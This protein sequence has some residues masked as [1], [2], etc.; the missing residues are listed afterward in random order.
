MRAMRLGWARLASVLVALALACAVVACGSSNDSSTSSSG[1]KA[2][3]ASSVEVMYTFD[4]LF[5]KPIKEALAGLP[6]KGITP[7]LTLAGKDY[8]SLLAKIQADLAAGHPADLTQ[9]S[10]NVLPSLVKAGAIK[11][12]DDLVASDP[13]VTKQLD[14]TFL[15]LGKVDGKQYALPYV[16]STPILLYNE[17]VFKKAGLD[18]NSPPQTWSEVKA[19]AQKIVDT[20]AARFGYLDG[21][22]GNAWI[23]E[24]YVQGMGGSML[25]QDQTKATFNDERGVRALTYW[26]DLV[27]AKLF[28]VLSDPDAQAAFL[29]GDIGMI[30]NSTARL[31]GLQSAAKFKV[32][33]APIPVPDGGQR[34]TP[35]AGNAWAIMTKDP[36]KRAAAWEALK[37]LDGPVGSTAVTK[38]T[39]YMPVNSV[40]RNTPKYL[41]AFYDAHPEYK[42]SLD[43]ISTLTTWTAFPG[44]RGVEIYDTLLKTFQSAMEGKTPPKEALDQAAQKIDELIQT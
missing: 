28:P 39:G 3:P 22:D 17:D 25:N 32:R 35:A 26:R 43:Q 5:T 12:I 13:S 2:K 30:V 29:K 37:L 9:I 41:G 10:L 15:D 4:E 1:A 24:S 7:K 6:A 42:T 18:P 23:F 27:K 20:H 14:K 34:K 33:T 38:A 8:P 40:A 16:T 11:P 44:T 31:S 21:W 19:A 36:A